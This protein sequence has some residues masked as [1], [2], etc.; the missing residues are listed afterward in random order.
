MALSEQQMAQFLAAQQ[1]QAREQ[2]L[3]RRHSSGSSSSGIV[4]AQISRAVICLRC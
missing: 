1:A 3:V 2:I 4:A